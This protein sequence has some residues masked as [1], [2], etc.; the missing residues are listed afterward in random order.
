MTIERTLRLIAGVVVMASVLL[1]MSVDARFYWLTLFVGVNLFQ[2]GFTNWCPMMSILRRVG[3]DRAR[4]G[5]AGVLVLLAAGAFLGG[6]TL[7]AEPQGRSGMQSPPMYNVATEVTLTGTIDEVQT[8]AGPS[9]QGG[10]HV[11][12]KTSTETIR[13]NIGPSWFMTQEKYALAKGDAVAVTGSRVKLD[14]G[15]VVI[16]REIK[17]GAQTMTFRDAKGFP[18]WSGRGRGQR[19]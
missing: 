2:S 1:G 6:A 8:I 11:V 10:V 13:V 19:G 14:T 7:S 3:A 17:K 16:A 15:E 9:G 18:K 5:V 12:L 4:P